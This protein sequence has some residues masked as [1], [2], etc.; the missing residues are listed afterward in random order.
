MSKIYIRIICAVL[1]V[2]SA[3][4]FL[5]HGLYI[6]KTVLP[7]VLINKSLP[8]FRLPILKQTG[9]VTKEK[10]LTN[11]ELLGAPWLLTVWASW[12]V[13]CEQ[14]NILLLQLHQLQRIKMIGFDYKDSYK[15]AQ[16]WLRNYGNPYDMV[17]GDDKGQFG[18]DLGVYGV[19]E[20]YFID[21]SGVVRKK[22]IGILKG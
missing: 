20:S 11:K 15:L 9:S 1:S 4:F 18:M 21:A 3:V 2:S 22:W 14:E 13:S 19:P 8:A 10:I 6:N 5:Y 17:V 7:S 16:R 12:C